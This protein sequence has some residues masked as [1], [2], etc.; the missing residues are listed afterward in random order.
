V[1]GR[2]IVRVEDSQ[3]VTDAELTLQVLRGDTAQW[4][5]RVPPGGETVP[6]LKVSVQDEGRVQ[7]IE[8]S[9][10]E[11]G[12]G[13]TV[14][15]KE[16][17]AEPLR[18]TLHQRQRRGNNPTAVGPFAVVDAISQ[19]GELEVRV[20]EDLRVRYQARGEVLQRNVSEEQ[21]REGVRT[22]FSYWGVPS[23]E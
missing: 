21:R 6:E 16:A 12:H 22:A 19:K 2:I 1:T 14:R 13:L 15:L 8:R 7:G 17:S 18:V 5:L 23:A 9:N 20:P 3:V 11:L 4:R 10:D